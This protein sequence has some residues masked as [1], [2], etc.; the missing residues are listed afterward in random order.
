MG[1]EQN[2]SSLEGFYDISSLIPRLSS[3][4]NNSCHPYGLLIAQFET[5]S[6]ISI[7]DKSILIIL[8]S[9]I[10]SYNTYRFK[11]ECLVYLQSISY[12]IT[13]IVVFVIN[14][15]KTNK[16]LFNYKKNNHYIETKFSLRSA[17]FINVCIYVN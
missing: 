9:I 14:Y 2:S 1:I 4:F 12:I 13:F 10:L 15:K 3:W 16:I 8:C 11:I 7:Q 6:I 17:V 5:N